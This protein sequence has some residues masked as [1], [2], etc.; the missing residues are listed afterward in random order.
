MPR[1]RASPQS[2]MPGGTRASC[3]SVPRYQSVAPVV[4][5]PTASVTIRALSS[6]TA[7]R[8][9]LMRPISVANKSAPQTATRIASS[10]PPEDPRTIVLESVTTAG[11][12]KSM[13]RAIS[14]SVS[15]IAAMARKAASG[16]IARNV[17][18]KRLRGAT[19]AQKTINPSI[20]IQIA[21]KRVRNRNRR[22]AGAERTPGPT[23]SAL[24][25]MLMALSPLRRGGQMWPGCWPTRAGSA[26][27]R[28]KA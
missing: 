7:T 14:T 16:M 1:K 17:D 6:N 4:M 10:W 11:I 3:G 27:A 28:N 26:A 15:P 22:E 19:M 5:A 9:P 18:G 12:D 20:A 24:A 23:A 21:A 2:A 25:R 8:M 13:P